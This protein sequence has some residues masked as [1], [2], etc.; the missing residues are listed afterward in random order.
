MEST[1]ITLARVLE[2]GV[3]VSWREATAIV[4]E[5]VAGTGAIEGAGPAR[6]TAE[7]CLL[8][9][10]GDVVLV[11]TAAQAPPEAVVRL[12]DDLL[13]SCS[14]PGRFAG[15]VANGTALDML[16][17]L[18]EHITPK[19]RR[20]E[21]AA[22]AL[23]GLAA[24]ADAARAM[25]DAARAGP[26]GGLRRCHR[27]AH[28]SSVADGLSAAVGQ[29]SRPALGLR[30]RQRGGAQAGLDHEDLIAAVEAAREWTAPETAV[31]ALAIGTSPAQGSRPSVTLRPASFSIDL[32][33]ATP[34]VNAVRTAKDVRG[35]DPSQF[36]WVVSPAA[37]VCSVL[38]VAA[39]GI[40]VLQIPATRRSAVEPSEPAIEPPEIDAPV[41]LDGHT[42]L[43]RPDPALLPEVAD[44]PSV[45]PVVAQSAPRGSTIADRTAPFSRA[46]ASFVRS[47]PPPAGGPETPAENTA[48]VAAG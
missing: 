21:V 15:A 38:A 5:A 28:A 35:G 45:P 17:E 36:G 25:A 29:G 40:L 30:L 7:S 42:P 41:G 39:S 2:L 19:R 27:R 11:G 12:L 47:I 23:R 8:T 24:A 14:A 9:R 46:Q 16:E 33:S 31:A 32:P 6:V 48:T 10:G 1:R 26:I 34:Q 20:V 43:A 4:H 22:V 3:R 37:L 44:P 18:S 13:A